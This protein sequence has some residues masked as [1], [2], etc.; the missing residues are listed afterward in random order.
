MV[1]VVVVLLLLLLL[2]LLTTTTVHLLCTNTQKRLE[3]AGHASSW[4]FEKGFRLH[5]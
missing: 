1:V 5:G 3:R 4:P 2:L